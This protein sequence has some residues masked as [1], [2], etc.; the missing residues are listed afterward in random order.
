MRNRAAARFYRFPFSRIFLLVIKPNP[1]TLIKAK[2]VTAI[3]RGLRTPMAIPIPIME[4]VA[5]NA[6]HKNGHFIPLIIFPLDSTEFSKF[7]H[8]IIIL[9]KKLL[10]FYLICVIIFQLD[11]KIILHLRSGQFSHV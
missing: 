7:F 1:I 5:A 6:K 4:R 8:P 3:Q 10:S 9:H 2:S 11:Y